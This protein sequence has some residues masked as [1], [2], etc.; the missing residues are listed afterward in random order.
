M[1]YVFFGKAKFFTGKFFTLETNFTNLR[2]SNL[3]GVVI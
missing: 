3:K 1:F 2:A